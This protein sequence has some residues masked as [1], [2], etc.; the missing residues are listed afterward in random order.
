MESFSKLSVN[1]IPFLDVGYTYRTLQNEIDFAIS[2]V[3]HSGQYIGGNEVSTFESHFAHFVEASHCVGVGNGLDAITLSLRALGVGPGDEV[4]VPSHTF[5][6]TWLAV[7]ETGATPVPVDTSSGGYN[8]DIDQIPAAVNSRTRGIIVVH[9]YGDPVD[10]DKVS[11]VAR[12]FNLWVIEDA[13]QAHGARFKG[14]RIGALSTLTTWSFYPGKNLGA[15]GDAGAVTTNDAALANVIR[16]M[17]NY[18]ASKKY[19]HDVLGLNSRLDP[20]H[21]AILDVKLRHLDSWNQRRKEIARKYC[22]ALAGLNGLELPVFSDSSSWHL[23]V[24]RSTRRDAL[25]TRLEQSGIGFGIHYP[26]PPHR[27]KPYRHRY[28]ESELP[29]TD[30]LSTQVLSLPI[31]PHLDDASVEYVIQN[32]SQAVN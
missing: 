15:F 22:A 21:A 31:G 24:V 11:K 1:K 29:V 26:T 9:L 8:L 10:L 27:Q 6:A 18:G 7:S 2:R 19:E 32:V 4:I 23:F 12:D 16:V 5:I 25:C 3:L 20:L 30:R 14:Q 28:T 13:A 17:G